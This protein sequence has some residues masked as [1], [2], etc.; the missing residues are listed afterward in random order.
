MKLPTSS[1][2]RVNVRRA[3]ELLADVNHL[4][5]TSISL[6]CDGEV[7][8]ISQRALIVSFESCPD[9]LEKKN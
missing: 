8:R 3:D 9:V 1:E 5:N 7:T 2:N 6:E 4:Q